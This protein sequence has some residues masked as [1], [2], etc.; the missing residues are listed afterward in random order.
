MKFD[1][2][3]PGLTISKPELEA[4]VLVASDDVARVNLHCVHIDP[5]ARTLVT[6]NGWMLMLGTERGFREEHRGHGVRRTVDAPPQPAPGPTINIPL[7]HV[8]AWLRFATKSDDLVLTWNAHFVTAQIE[9][10]SL[11]V[12]TG[13]HKFPPRRAV[14]LKAPAPERPTAPTIGLSLE[15]VKTAMSALQKVAGRPN[16]C[17]LWHFTNDDQI[18]D[19]NLL[20]TTITV[21][22]EDA[23]W[24]CLVMPMRFDDSDD[25]APWRDAFPQPPEPK[26][27]EEATDP[28]R[29][30]DATTPEAIEQVR[31]K[32]KRPRR[33]PRAKVRPKAK[34]KPSTKKKAKRGRR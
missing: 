29:P 30:M 3:K 5:W 28:A 8:V 4:L 14:L 32:R 11:H 20:P 27:E 9:E 22:A 1:N 7:K 16:A 15:A 13:R 2:D 21:R 10:Q 34:R 26:K 31:A 19:A 6:T 12:A 23:L 17:A 24:R 18:A 33:K 25:V